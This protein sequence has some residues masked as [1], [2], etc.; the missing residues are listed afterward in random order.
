[1]TH[2]TTDIYQTTMHVYSNAAQAASVAA[3]KTA[4]AATVAATEL[5]VHGRRLAKELL[6]HAEYGYNKAIETYHA[7]YKKQWPKIKPHYDKHL[8]PV[9]DKFLQW[10]AKEVDPKLAAVG[11]QYRKIKT[12]EIDPRLQYL[13]SER[14]KLFSRMVAAY[15]VHCRDAYKL[16]RQLARE[17]GYMEKFQQVGPHIKDSCDNAEHS[18]TIAVRVVAILL[19]LP[20]TGRIF[21][22]AWWLVR[23]VVH[24]FLTITLLR[25][26]LPR[27]GPKT[28]KKKTKVKKEQ[29]VPNKVPS[30]SGAAATKK[31]GHRNPVQ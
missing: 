9:V 15:E 10:K 30:N 14:K 26:I 27:G 28:T 2:I 3:S 16:S 25:F 12:E 7:Q 24:I 31:R 13:N 1:M 23:M 17:H 5:N 4:E 11:E 20:F 6:V 19:L 22:L 18:M 29:P 21:G 8:S